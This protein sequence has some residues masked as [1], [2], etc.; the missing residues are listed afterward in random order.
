MRE[1]TDTMYEDKLDLALKHLSSALELL[2]DARAPGDIG[3]HVDL[4]I[5]RL[6]DVA[7]RSSSDRNEG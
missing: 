2:D 3:A 6:K 5:S 1:T 4:A 7:G